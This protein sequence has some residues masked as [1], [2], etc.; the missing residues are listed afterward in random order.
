[1]T[2]PAIDAR[3]PPAAPTGVHH[4][5][6]PTMP[7]THDSLSA[8][9]TLGPREMSDLSPQTGTKRTLFKCAAASLCPAL[10]RGFADSI[11]NRECVWKRQPRAHVLALAPYLQRDA[12]GIGERYTRTAG[13]SLGPMLVLWCGLYFRVTLRSVIALLSVRHVYPDSGTEN[14][15]A[16]ETD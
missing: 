12:F 15:N 11:G 9:G 13:V 3:V 6:S 14:E 4:V 10:L 8:N 2:R 16:P 1:V 5:R 7:S